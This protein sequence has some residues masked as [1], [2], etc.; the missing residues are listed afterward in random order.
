MATALVVTLSL[1]SCSAVPDP[2]ATTAVKNFAQLAEEQLGA[3]TS[4]DS[5]DASQSP[6]DAGAGADPRNADLWSVDITVVMT[7]GASVEQ[8]AA[9]ASEERSFSAR[10]SGSGHWAAYLNAA[11]TA[12]PYAE[13]TTP[14]PVV[15]LQVFPKARNSTTE[16]AR[17]AMSIATIA[18]INSIAVV[19]SWPYLNVLDAAT[20]GA[21]YDQTHASTLFDD[22]GTYGTADGRVKIVDIPDRLDAAGIH[23]IIGV[24]AAYPTAAIALEASTS[25]QRY[26]VLFFDHVSDVEAAAIAATLSDNRLAAKT[27]GY[28]VPFHIRGAGPTGTTDT[29][30]TF[31]NAAAS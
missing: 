18:G 28:V 3:L 26:P 17:A 30:G 20:I 19:G 12:Q 21:V 22:G 15:G 14:M 31:G 1:T 9:A 8:V 27:G 11:G 25:G 23:A 16:M 24:A 2:A 10:Y 4:V 7:V 13:D 5:V 29:S 6:G